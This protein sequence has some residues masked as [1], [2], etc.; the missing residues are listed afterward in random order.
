LRQILAHAKSLSRTNR[1]N[2]TR[3]GK[4]RVTDTGVGIAADDLPHVFEAFRQ[5]NGTTRR[6]HG[7]L[8]IGLAI[9]RQVVELHG[10]RVEAR[11]EGEGR[12]AEFIVTLPLV[13]VAVGSPA[14]PATA[15]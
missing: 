1:V 14:M 7:G 12:G 5:A 4:I 3:G 15:S 6:R 10:G 13:R 2:E 8:G 11:S 9:V